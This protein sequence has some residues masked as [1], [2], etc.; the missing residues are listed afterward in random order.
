MEYLWIDWGVPLYHGVSSEPLQNLLGNVG[1]H[2]ALEIYELK[3]NLVA[4]ASTLHVMM[5]SNEDIHSMENV[6]L[7][8][9]FAANSFYPG[10]YD[11]CSERSSR[12]DEITLFSLRRQELTRLLHS[13]PLHRTD[14]FDPVSLR[15][16]LQPPPPEPE[17]DPLVTFMS[18]NPRYIP[19]YIEL[20]KTC[21][22]RGQGSR[23]SKHCRCGLAKHQTH[24]LTNPRTMA[25][26]IWRPKISTRRSQ[27][28]YPL[29]GC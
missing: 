27:V 12:W 19:T 26:N 1:K 8:L 10:N 24:H 7:A 11:C 23:Q 20:K 3:H 21:P 18:Q 16:T 14:C 13:P 28:S 2:L 22:H 6:K 17:D 4:T 29:D 5:E 9:K 15:I 25:W